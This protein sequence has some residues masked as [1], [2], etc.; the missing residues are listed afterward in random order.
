MFTRVYFGFRLILDH[1][2]TCLIV[3]TLVSGICF[4]L[5]I[6]RYSRVSNYL[7]FYSLFPPMNQEHV[8]Q[9]SS[10]EHNNTVIKRGIDNI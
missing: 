6:T 2:A 8:I 7:M 3:C 5:T 9:Q 10:I 1:S 4:Y